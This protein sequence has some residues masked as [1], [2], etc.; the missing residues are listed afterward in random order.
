MDWIGQ[1]SDAKGNAE[2]RY[3]LLADPETTQLEHD[4]AIAVDHLLPS[5]HKLM[6]K[7]RPGASCYV[8]RYEK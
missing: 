2:S 4:A 1:L 7:N 8:I 5:V 3:V 6:G